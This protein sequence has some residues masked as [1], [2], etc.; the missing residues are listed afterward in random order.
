MFRNNHH[1]IVGASQSHEKAIIVNQ[2]AIKSAQRASIAQ[3]KT[4]DN[5]ANKEWR[6]NIATRE[7]S[8]YRTP[9]RSTIARQMVKRE[10]LTKTKQKWD[11]E[12]QNFKYCKQV[13]CN[14]SAASMGIQRAAVTT[15]LT[16]TAI[17]RGR[18]RK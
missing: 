8:K 6:I 15:K 13:Q 16:I 9:A 11:Q 4:N 18:D 7:A 14:K 2:K 17:L 1:Q 10:L 12:S 3:Q 5:P